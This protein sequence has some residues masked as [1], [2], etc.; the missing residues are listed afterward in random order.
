[1]NELQIIFGLMLVGGIASHY[2]LKKINKQEEKQE[3]ATP[4]YKNISQMAQNL[5]ICKAST[6][7]TVLKELQEDEKWTDEDITELVGVLNGMLDENIVLNSDA[8]S[9]AFSI[10]QPKPKKGN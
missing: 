1:M 7:L 6:R 9:G 10:R 5:S 3:E 4:N 8:K 2:L